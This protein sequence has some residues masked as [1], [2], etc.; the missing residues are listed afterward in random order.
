MRALQ[1]VRDTGTLA[2][3]ILDWTDHFQRNFVTLND[4]PDGA[5]VWEAGA[6][7]GRWCARGDAI[8]E[9]L[10]GALPDYEIDPAYTRYVRP[11]N[12]NRRLAGLPRR[13]VPKSAISTRYSP[14]GE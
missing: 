10:A 1:F 14:R 4:D 9:K 2:Q 12:E 11:A 13:D 3:E 5:P 6:D 8:I 7:V